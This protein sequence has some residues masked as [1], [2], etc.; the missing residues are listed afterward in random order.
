MP[1]TR[2]RIL[3]VGEGVSL[4]HVSRPLALIESLDPSEYEIH[5]ACAKRYEPLIGGVKCRFWPLESL[6]PEAFMKAL[7]RGTPPY[8]YAQLERY[9]EED[10]KLLEAIQPEVVIGDFRFTLFVSAALVGVPHIA[11]CN[12]YLSP[13]SKRKTYPVPEHPSVKIFGPGLVGA[14]FPFLAPFFFSRYAA[15][16]QK[17]AKR[18]GRPIPDGLWDICA[19]GDYTLYSDLPSLVP[20]I[21]LPSHHEYLGPIVWSPKVPLPAWW[22]EI[23]KERPTVY[24]SMGSSG[25]TKTV[26]ILL[27]VLGELNANIILSTAGRFEPEVSRSVWAAPYLPGSEAAKRSSLVI[28]N[29]GSPSVYQ[30]LKE[31]VPILG[32]PSNLDQYLMI[33]ALKQFGAGTYLRAGT[34][35][36]EELRKT[37]LSLLAEEH[38]RRQ[39]KVLAEEFLRFDAKVRFA[40]FLKRT[41]KAKSSRQLTAA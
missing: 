34:L 35:T 22:E 2:K 3:F 25:D 24:V 13:H 31:G 7:A 41:L 8:H 21:E 14:V 33:T 20:T 17:L 23:P 29:G 19:Q 9:V 37:I 40:S 26:P 38:Y 39:A 5:F 30:A 36:H 10:R 28:C 6:S 15:P 27:S 4:A 32:I 12:A 18:F 11:L 16:F 1:E